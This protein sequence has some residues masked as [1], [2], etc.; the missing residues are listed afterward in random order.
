MPAALSFQ[1]HHLA[2]LFILIHITHDGWLYFAEGVA[3]S[4]FASSIEE[5]GGGGFNFKP[6]G[7]EFPLGVFAWVGLGFVLPLSLS[8]AFPSPVTDFTYSSLSAFSK[9]PTPG[10]LLFNDCSSRGLHGF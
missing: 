4:T 2:Q 10:F 3:I 1:Q 9:R 8:S 5:V 7:S 6:F